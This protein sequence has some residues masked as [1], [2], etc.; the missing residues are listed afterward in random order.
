MT[1][2]P[3]ASPQW[4]EN[5]SGLREY[6]TRSTDDRVVTGV[7]GGLAARLG[8]GSGYVRAGFVGLALTGLGLVLYPV[9]YVLSAGTAPSVTLA[10]SP[11]DGRQKVGLAL[12]FAGVTVA[13]AVLTDPWLNGPALA[14]LILIAFGVAAVWDRSVSG[15]TGG[16]TNQSRLRIIMGAAV[17]LAGMALLIGASYRVS[18]LAPIALAVGIT[19]AGV[20]LVFGP[21][22]MRLATDLAEERRDRIRSEERAE[23]AAH[24]HDSVLQTF[25]M[26]Q[27]TDDPRKMATLARSQERELRAWLYG[28]RNSEHG[29]MLSDALEEMADRVEQ[30]SD[31][32][33]EVVVVSDL[34]MG[35]KLEAVVAASGEAMTNA[36]RHSGAGKVSVYAEVDGAVLEVFVTDQGVGFDSTALPADRH[37]LRE[38][39][40][41]R[42]QRHGGA[43]AVVSEPGEGTEVH[44]TMPLE[45]S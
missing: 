45:A 32:P 17:I 25:A 20:L 35:P 16:D 7:A 41:G 24:L 9:L 30:A 8:M 10:R 13:A 43:A 4:A 6:L 5:W 11:I 26:I 40:I 29:R 42:M 38:S 28:S 2:S 34:A 37:G 19:G 44:L 39:V 18:D 21:W 1:T 31:V 27:R 15:S 23:M 33:V 14:A 3:P 12:M 36:A 22:A